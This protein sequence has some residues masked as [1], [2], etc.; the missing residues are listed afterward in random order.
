MN[1][2]FKLKRCPQ[3]TAA[4]SFLRS[5]AR[6][7]GRHRPLSPLP[8]SPA[9]LSSPP[10]PPSQSLRRRRRLRNVAAVATCKKDTRE[11]ESGA[12]DPKKFLSKIMNTSNL[13]RWKRGNRLCFTVF[14]H[15]H[16]WNEFTKCNHSESPCG[17]SRHT[18]A[19]A[20]THTHTNS[21]RRKE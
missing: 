17:R 9:A 16:P 3:F 8:T 21:L 7:L 5:L 13:L 12:S 14:E 1:R 18:Q 19:H 11:T 15:C 4:P 2:P 6:S 20:R 10:P